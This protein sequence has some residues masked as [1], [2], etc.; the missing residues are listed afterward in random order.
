MLFL[1]QTTAPLLA[2]TLW[3]QH[4]HASILRQVT[5]KDGSASGQE[6]QIQLTNGLTVRFM[7]MPLMDRN[8]VA[9]KSET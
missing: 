8:L 9:V 4:L 1:G 3:R 2:L 5:A 7:S 6:Q